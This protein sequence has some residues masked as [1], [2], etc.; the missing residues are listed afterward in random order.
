MLL[1][2]VAWAATGLVFFTKPGYGAAYDAL[3]VRTYPLG[4]P[5]AVTPDPSWR[6]MRYLRTILGVHLLVRT[7]EGWSQ[8]NPSTRQALGEPAP[9]DVRR[10][11]ADAF[12][13]N[14]ARY[15]Q[16]A[17]LDGSVATTDTGAVVTLDWKRLALQQR[18][19]DT[20]R[21]DRLYKVHYLQWTGE[22]TVDRI[23]G[24]AGLVLLLVLTALGARLAFRRS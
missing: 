16:I 24:L 8:L 7:A 21:I 12:A 1:P 19:R 17:S 14:P 6:E 23:L 18:G 3:P 11:I 2:F 22:K 15:G 5:I 9:A 4:D 10:L 20:D 13:A